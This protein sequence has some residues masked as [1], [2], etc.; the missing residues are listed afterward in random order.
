M[1]HMKFSD[2]ERD[3]FEMRACAAIEMMSQASSR[4]LRAATKGELYE[5]QH[6]SILLAIESAVVEVKRLPKIKE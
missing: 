2:E 1:T 6:R 5:E 3:N 4:M